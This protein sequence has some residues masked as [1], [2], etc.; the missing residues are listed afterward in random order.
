MSR[1]RKDMDTSTIFQLPKEVPVVVPSPPTA[2]GENVITLSPEDEYWNK[3]DQV[4]AACGGSGYM[5]IVGLGDDDE[6]DDEDDEDD[7]EG[8]KEN[9]KKN[10]TAEQLDTLRLV[11][12]NDRRIK[13]LDKAEKFTDPN[14]GWFNTSTGN[15]VIFGIPSE[16]KK[17]M[18]FKTFPEKFD[19]FFALTYCLYENDIWMNDNE[20]WGQGSELDQAIS[21]LGKTWKS[22][23]PKSNEELGIDEYTR[24]GVEA[25]LEKFEETVDSCESI[26]I[27]FEWK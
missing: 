26:N 12:L 5:I 25:L 15:K 27:S 4:K 9:V 1:K 6:E 17:A 20:C 10:Y 7:Y 22:L 13:F 19:A 3:V 16:V 21:I 2:V 23:L 24:N 14:D 8:D 18:K 11:I